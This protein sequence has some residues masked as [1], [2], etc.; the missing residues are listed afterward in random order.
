LIKS[1]YDYL[2]KLKIIDQS[3]NT[4]TY[5]ETKNYIHVFIFSKEKKDQPVIHSI[6]DIIYLS[7]YEVIFYYFLVINIQ[8]RSKG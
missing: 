8:Q 5:Q 7:R 1:G 2:T 3:L 6:G 4:T